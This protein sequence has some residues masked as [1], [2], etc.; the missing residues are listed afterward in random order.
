MSV[1]GAA[2]AVVA[3]LLGAGVLDTETVKPAADVLEESVLV[4]AVGL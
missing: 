1:L 2:V 4:A 3:V